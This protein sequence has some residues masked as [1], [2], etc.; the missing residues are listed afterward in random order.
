[1]AMVIGSEI[2][3]HS[4]E[5]SS[6]NQSITV[7]SMTGTLC[8]HLMELPNVGKAGVKILI[9]RLPESSRALWSYKSVLQ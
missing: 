9:P 5:E 2:N 6:S 4:A 3:R 7:L 8:H 1:M